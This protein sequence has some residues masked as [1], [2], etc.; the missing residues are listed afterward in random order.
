MEG[1]YGT[2]YLDRAAGA[3]EGLL[4]HDHPE[5]MYFS[6]YESYVPSKD[7]KSSDKGQFQFLINGKN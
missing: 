1:S 6:T 7:A 5:C 4:V 2:D 3:L